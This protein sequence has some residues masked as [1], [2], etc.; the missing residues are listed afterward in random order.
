[1]TAPA[2]ALDA[3]VSVLGG[4]LLNPARALGPAREWLRPADFFHPAHAE[5]YTALLELDA[6]G[7]PLDVVTLADLLGPQLARMGGVEWLAGLTSSVPTV[8]H[9]SYHARIVA[10]HSLTRQVRSALSRCQASEAEGENL[11]QESLSELGLIQLP[12]LSR[13]ETL[14]DGMHATLSAVEKLAGSEMLG[15]RTYLHD[16]DEQMAGLQPGVMTIVGARPQQGKSSLVALWAQNIAEHGG[17]VDYYSLE[18]TRRSLH[19]RMLAQRAQVDNRKLRGGN[20]T[21]VE[22]AH[23]SQAASALHRFGDKLTIWDDLP[24]DAGTFCVS[25]KQAALRRKTDLIVIDYIQLLTSPSERGAKQS[26]NDELTAISRDLKR[27]PK[28][29]GCAL[30]VCCQLSRETERDGSPQLHHLRDCGALEQDAHV[31]VMLDRAR[32]L[33]DGDG[34][35]I[36]ACWAHVRKNKDGGTGTVPLSWRGEYVLFGDADEETA[37]MCWAAANAQKRRARK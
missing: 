24:R 13:G 23:V 19:L 36:P 35:P 14:R 16:L 4:I 9:I 17:T 34:K 33:E 11:L 10:D 31:V 22:W 27:I 28:E 30:V 2:A 5:V 12:Q 8:E 6:A 7:R 37:R 21:A 18:D 15:L 32:W 25:V 3:E 29:I 1:M 26:R 20:L